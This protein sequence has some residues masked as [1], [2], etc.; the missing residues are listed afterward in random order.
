LEKR[1]G[2][3]EQALSLGHSWNL[4]VGDRNQWNVQRVLI[5]ST[6]AEGSVAQPKSPVVAVVD[7]DLVGVEVFIAHASSARETLILHTSQQA[8]CWH[9][10]L[11][12]HSSRR[13]WSWSSRTAV[14]AMLRKDQ[15]EAHDAVVE[16]E[17]SAIHDLSSF[18]NENKNLILNR[19]RLILKKIKSASSCSG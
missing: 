15:G 11:R 3:A 2:R 5:G 6:D 18:G 1:K 10:R 17:L 14:A 7:V 19:I 4:V 16:H 8:R 9:V 13:A 12:R